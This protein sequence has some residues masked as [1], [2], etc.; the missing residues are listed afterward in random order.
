MAGGAPEKNSA[1]WFPHLCGDSASMFFLKTKYQCKGYMTW[2]MILEDLCKKD[3]HF[4][5]LDKKAELM[6]LSARCYV[7]EETL[8]NIINDLVDL[9]EFNKC[10]WEKKKVIFSQK[11][12]DSLKELYKK[13]KK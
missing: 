11:F 7:S 6:R 1:E 2:F 10:L 3:F 9:E 12:C 4:L 8:I 5:C 13:R